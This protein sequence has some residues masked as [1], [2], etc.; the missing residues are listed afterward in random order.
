[1]VA[2]AHSKSGDTRAGLEVLSK[3]ADLDPQNTDVRLQLAENYLQEGMLSE[4]AA[5]FTEAGDNLQ[6]RGSVDDAVN[7]FTRSLDIQPS[8]AATLSGLLAAH[9]A[10]GTA[11]E[12]AELIKRASDSTPDNIDLLSLLATAYIQ[13]EDPPQAEIATAALVEKEPS[14]YL[15]FIEVAR[16]YLSIDQLDE[17]ARLVG[18]IAEQMLSDREDRQLLDLVNELL[19]RDGDHVRALRLLVRVHWWQRDVDNLRTALDR[20]AEAAQTAGLTDDERYALTQ[21][22]RLA[23]EQALYAARLQELGGATTEAAAEVLPEFATEPAEN[24][25]AFVHEFTIEHEDPPSDDAHAFEWN[26]PTEVAEDH[27][28]D[29]SGDLGIERGFTFE[30]VVGEELPQEAVHD[31]DDDDRKAG[32]RAQELESVDFYIAQGYADIAIDTLN[33]LESQFGQHPDIELRRRQLDQGSG[34][35]ASIV[36]HSM[37][38]EHEAESVAEFSFVPENVECAPLSEVHEHVFEKPAVTVP[39]IDA[40]LAEVF[41]EYRVSA[42]AETNG[43]GDYETHYNLGL[44][45][46]EMDLFEEALEEFQIAVGI[47]SPDDG[48]PRYLQCCNLLGHCF[49]RKGVPQL[50]IKWFNKGLGAPNTSEDERQALRFDLAAAYEQAGDLNQAKNLFTEIYG[51][52]VSYRGVNERLKSLE[53]RMM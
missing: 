6:A 46:Q 12:A 14:A 49:M 35:A 33:L 23:P 50:A 53:S 1:A 44:A 24:E 9:T 43:N 13:A 27:D 20:L 11:D 3:I 4:A 17:A 7:A 45:Y 37:P 30:A 41:E 39:V 34:A 52:N 15:R 48:T 28:D 25:V 16:L 29:R 22:T 36:D 51:V 18:S 40:G 5:A 2:N 47:V 32:M 10:R 21:L 38:V 42:E 26:A 31:A 19:A 8:D